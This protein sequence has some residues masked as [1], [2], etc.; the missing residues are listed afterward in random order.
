MDSNWSDLPSSIRAEGVAQVLN[1]TF[2]AEHTSGFKKFIE[3]A[4]NYGWEEIVERSG[5]QS[6]AFAAIVVILFSPRADQAYDAAV[7]LIVGISMATVIAAIVKFAVL[8]GVMGFAAF[9]MVLGVVLVPAGAVMV[10]TLP[11]AIFVPIACFFVPLLARAKQMRYD[12]QQFY[13][14]SSAIFTGVG[15]AALAFRLLPPLSPGHQTRRPLA[16]TLRDLRRLATAPIAPTVDNWKSLIYN[17]LSVLPRQADPLR[18]AQ[19]LAALS[20]GTELIRLRCLVQLVGP[21]PQLAGIA[22]HFIRSPA[23]ETI[24]SRR[25]S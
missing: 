12:P 18:R 22:Q 7:S 24:W 19:L 8:P 25:I 10:Q 3:A 20:L 9:S 17:C 15:L 23:S 16:L 2:I 14:A 6:V 1:H 4:R 11:T 5:F 13:N 21:L